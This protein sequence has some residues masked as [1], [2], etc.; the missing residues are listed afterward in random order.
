V[1]IG[2]I[3]EMTNLRRRPTILQ[4]PIFWIAL[5]I[6]ILLLVGPSF[7]QSFRHKALS[8]A[9]DCTSLTGKKANQF[10]YELDSGGWF[11]CEPTSGDCDTAGEWI[12]V[13]GSPGTGAFL[14]SGDPVV[15]NTPTKDVVIG[16][17]QVN[18]SKLSID[19]D[20]DQVQLT[21]QGNGTQTADLVSFEDSAGTGFFTV[22]GDGKAGFGTASPDDIVGLPFDGTIAWGS[23]SGAGRFITGASS[24]TEGLGLFSKN[25]IALVIDSDNN[26]SGQKFTIAADG[27]TVASATALFAVT[28]DGDVGVGRD[29]AAGVDFELWTA[30][31]DGLFSIT[32]DGSGVDSRFA[33]AEGTAGDI[34][35]YFEYDGTANIGYIGMGDS[36]AP[37]GAWSK[38]IQMT[39]GGTEVEFPVGDVDISN[40]DLIISGLVDGVDVSTLSID[41]NAGTICTGTNTYLDGEG[42]CDIVSISGVGG[43]G[44]VGTIPKYTATTT[45]GDSIITELTGEIGINIAAPDGTLHVHTATAGAVTAN[46]GANDLVVENSSGAGISILS[47]AANTGVIAFGTGTSNFLAGIQWA[48]SVDQYITGTSKAGASYVLRSGDS[49]LALILDSAQEVQVQNILHIVPKASAPATCSI[50]DFYVDTSGAACACSSTNTWTEMHGVGSCV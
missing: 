2:G 50:G 17:G 35:L 19:G 11:V 24:S 25:D 31:A 23:G 15:L 41:T 10:C 44:T 39:R 22:M 30:T 16:T 47:G 29:P 4:D 28:E 20:A 42:G 37:T 38:R 8:H 46:T 9:T 12:E 32:N 48:E 14:D 45:I 1:G 40:G 27:A 7:G 49:V 6:L 33:L 21:V 26:A 34:G 5:A 43:S 3:N 36:V 18:S 13:A